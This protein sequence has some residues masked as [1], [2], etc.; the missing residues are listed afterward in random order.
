MIFVL[1]AIGLTLFIILTLLSGWLAKSKVA[2]GQLWPTCFNVFY[3][4]CVCLKKWNLTF[5]CCHYHARLN[6]NI[7]VK[8]KDVMCL[9]GICFG[10]C[11]LKATVN[12]HN[13]GNVH[14]SIFVVQVQANT[15][16]ANCRFTSI[17]INNVDASYT[18]SKFYMQTRQIM[19]RLHFLTGIIY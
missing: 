11:R 19:A 15:S 4:I 2:M 7:S 1:K 5:K 12:K 3:Q 14:C 17:T 18:L 8:A 13:S 10:R 6:M 9:H 16:S